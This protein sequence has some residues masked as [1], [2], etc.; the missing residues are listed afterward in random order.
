MVIEKSIIISVMVVNDM[1]V[2]GFLYNSI[3]FDVMVNKSLELWF[4]GNV[5]LYYMFDFGFG[6]VD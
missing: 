3:I 5:M 4:E 1:L 6:D 2:F